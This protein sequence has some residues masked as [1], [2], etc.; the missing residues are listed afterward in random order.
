MDAK[1]YRMAEMKDLL[2]QRKL[3]IETNE[4]CSQKQAKRAALQKDWPLTK[5][6]GSV[7]ELLNDN[8]VLLQSL[9]KTYPCRTMRE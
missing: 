9:L 3:R 8:E 7:I 1:G 4:M 6:I 2:N 5:Q